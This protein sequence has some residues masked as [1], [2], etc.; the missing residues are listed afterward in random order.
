MLRKRR[1]GTSKHKAW[2]A[3]SKFIRQR[4]ANEDGFVACFT[5]GNNGHW[6]DMDAGHYIPKS[7]SLALRFDE[8][9]V[10]VQ[11]VGCNQWRHGNLTQYALALKRKYGE[12]ILEELDRDRRLGEGFK[13][14]ESGYVELFEKYAAK[15]K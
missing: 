14:Y 3:F 10:Q 4:E 8:R 15:L 12:N 13:I 5:C 6:K 11:C 2:D 9:N 1:K 7:V